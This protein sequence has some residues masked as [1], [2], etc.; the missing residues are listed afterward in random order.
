[1]F[2]TV[3][4]VSSDRV[5]LLRNLA[6][7]VYKAFDLKQVIYRCSQKKIKKKLTVNTGH[8]TFSKEIYY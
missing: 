6:V 8:V 5:Q 7:Y 4:L 3:E 1:M 2:K